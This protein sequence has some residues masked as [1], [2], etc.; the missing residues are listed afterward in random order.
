[1]FTARL[2]ATWAPVLG[3]LETETLW[4]HTMGCQASV[5]SNRLDSHRATWVNLQNKYLLRRLRN[6]VGYIYTTILFA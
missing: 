5:R 2:E 3:R 1:M 6:R 4:V